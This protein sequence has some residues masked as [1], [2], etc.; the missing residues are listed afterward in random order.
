MSRRREAVAASDAIVALP[1]ELVDRRR[2]AP[3]DDLVGVL[4]TAADGDALT[5][6]ELLSSLFQLIVAGH[7]TTTSLIGNGVV[8]L[9]DHPDQSPGCSS[10]AR[11]PPPSRS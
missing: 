4:V 3:A 9:L 6:Q 1:A 8:A 7:D 11:R 5:Q 10:R 2:S